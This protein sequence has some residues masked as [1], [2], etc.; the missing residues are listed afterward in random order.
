[1]VGKNL[2]YLGNYEVGWS[3][4]SAKKVMTP[5]MCNF[6]ALWE[7]MWKLIEQIVDIK[8]RGRWRGGKWIN[9]G[10]LLGGEVSR[11]IRTMER[12]I[13]RNFRKWRRKGGGNERRG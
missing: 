6:V 8:R 13:F 5:I 4:W 2:R 10:G 3:S 9:Y 11:N 1:M 7:E 12:E